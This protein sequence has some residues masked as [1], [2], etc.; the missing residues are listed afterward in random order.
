MRCRQ[1]QLLKI[2]IAQDD[3]VIAHIEETNKRLKHLV[4]QGEHVEHATRSLT[5]AIE[6]L[7]P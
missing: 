4:E 1:L 2:I 5:A 7:R 3:A 6:S